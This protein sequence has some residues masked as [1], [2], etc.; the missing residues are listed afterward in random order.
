MAHAQ[1][2][3]WL[4]APCP[5]CHVMPCHAALPLLCAAAGFGLTVGYTEMD[6]VVVLETTQAVNRFLEKQVR[7]VQ[8]P[9]CNQ[10]LQIQPGCASTCGGRCDG[11]APSA[12]CAAAGFLG[13]IVCHMHLRSSVQLQVE[14][15]AGATATLGPLG[16]ALPGN[17]Q[18][19]RA[20]RCY[21][22]SG[23]VHCALHSHAAGARELRK[24]LSPLSV[25]LG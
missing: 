12:G 3:H 13:C 24:A 8:L 25:S 14:M 11:T 10:R 7:S 18:V 1:P 17:M 19:R 23:K 21:T 2:A 15:G 9:N 6:S 4:A 22:A 5:S 16:E 20:H